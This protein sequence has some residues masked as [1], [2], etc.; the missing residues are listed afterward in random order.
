M[1]HLNESTSKIAQLSSEERIQFILGNKWVGYTRATEVLEKLNG[2]VTAPRTTRMRNFLLLGASNNGKTVII[3]RFEKNYPMYFDDKV[4]D[5]QKQVLMIE[6]P[7]YPDEVRFYQSILRKLVVPF[8]TNHKAE[9]LFDQVI[10]AFQHLDLKVLIID[11]VHHLN[12]DVGRKSSKQ[13]F[14]NSIKSLSNILSISIVAVGTK[15]AHYVFQ[16]DPQIAS[17]FEL[18]TLDRWKIDK[19][20]IRFL[21]SYEKILPLRKK[22]SLY[23]KELAI[24]ILSMTDSTIGG[25]CRVLREAAIMAIKSG[26]EKITVEVLNQ[27]KIL[28]PDK[29]KVSSIKNI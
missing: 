14:L 4:E 19:E 12:H 6:S 21:V 20:Y 18:I 26:Q 10:N 5:V 1:D 25:V 8:R 2:L 9:H 28:P 15:E 3:D 13:V 17:R 29:M 11:E 22:S 27:L 24:K 16:S 23:E 7:P